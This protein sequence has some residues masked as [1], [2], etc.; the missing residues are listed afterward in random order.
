MVLLHSQTKPTSR[1]A[2]DFDLLWVDGKHY[3]LADFANHTWLAVIF[4]CNH[5]PYAVASRPII[6]DLSDHYPDIAIVCI[7]SNDAA[8]VPEDS[9]EKMQALS[10]V[11]DFWF[12]YL[13]DA[14]Q[15]VAQAYDA[16]CTPDNYL[17]KKTKNT[18][19]SFELFFHGRFNDNRQDPSRVTHK[20]FE[21]H[22]I[23]LLA[24]Q[25]PSEI[26]PPSM[27]CSIKWK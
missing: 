13:Y 19:T 11:M 10:E 7:S 16:Q 25:K 1:T 24:G 15:S 6:I 17:F 26:Q 14:D 21:E 20:D 3:T 2:P 23:K 5:C 9:Y 27:G 4:T 12:P 22:I 8:Y 18:D